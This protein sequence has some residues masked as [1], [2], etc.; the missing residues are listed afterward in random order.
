MKRKA[1][2]LRL[3][4]PRAV[5][6]LDLHEPGRLELFPGLTHEECK[7]TMHLVMAD[8]RVYR[9]AEAVARTLMTRRVLGLFARAYYIP[10]LRSLSDMLYRFIAKRRYGFVLLLPVLSALLACGGGGGESATP[11]PVAALTVVSVSPDSVTPAAINTNVTLVFSRPLNAA[12]VD[13][14][15]N[16]L[17]TL[18]L[19]RAST[20][21]VAMTVVATVS[22]ASVTLDPATNLDPQTTYNVWISPSVTDTAGVGLAAL[23]QRTFTTSTAPDTTPPTFAGAA[24][25]VSLGAASNRVSWTAATDTVSPAG[26]ITY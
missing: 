18:L 14:N 10:V 15:T 19:E 21:P 5:E 1:D 11:A 17:G 12:T 4:G 26:S 16:G 2:I 25:A 20:P 9:G 24:S 23:V 7:R 6:A 22:G 3:A 13:A 8:G